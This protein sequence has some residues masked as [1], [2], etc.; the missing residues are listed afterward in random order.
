M[1]RRIYSA[2]EPNK[3]THII[4]LE[5]CPAGSRS[6]LTEDRDLMQI[7]RIGLPEG[8]I[9]KPHRHLKKSLAFTEIDQIECWIV[10]RGRLKISLFD[11]DFT[12]MESLEIS[13]G[14]LVVTIAGGHSID[15]CAPDT[16]LIEIKMG[17]Y[18]GDD[19]IAFNI[20]NV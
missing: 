1:T 20:T 16:E 2:R 3:L 4:T 13:V 15:W 7:S 5:S 11:V 9:V 19:K 6:N 18:I 10:T 14:A 17:P 12:L 8:K